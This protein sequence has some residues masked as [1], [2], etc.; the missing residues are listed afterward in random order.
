MWVCHRIDGEVKVTPTP[1]LLPLNVRLPQLTHTAH[2]LGCELLAAPFTPSHIYPGCPR[3]I[4]EEEVVL[5]SKGHHKGTPLH[6]Q[7]SGLGP[8]LAS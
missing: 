3:R 5:T 6:L 7:L 1:I 8:R 4:Q 2:H